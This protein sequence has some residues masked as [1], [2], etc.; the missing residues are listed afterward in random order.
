M[1]DERTDTFTFIDEHSI[2]KVSP[3]RKV[4][5]IVT[6]YARQK[7]V[8]LGYKYVIQ[9]VVFDCAAKIYSARDSTRYS[10]ARRKLV[11]D[12]ITKRVVIKKDTKAASEWEFVCARNQSFADYYSESDVEAA[13]N[14]YALEHS[15]REP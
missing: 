9:H 3:G 10:A 15:S 1:V 11:T 14:L 4:A 2:R 5:S 8:N 7:A 12:T 6:V 13:D